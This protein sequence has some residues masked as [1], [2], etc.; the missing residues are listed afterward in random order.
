MGRRMGWVGL[1]K[2]MTIRL[3]PDPPAG[4]SRTQTVVSDSRVQVE[5]DRAAGAT[6][7]DWKVRISSR[8]IG[9]ATMAVTKPRYER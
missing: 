2:S 6:P 7:I 8:R 4:A 3:P 5:K 1:A 9:P